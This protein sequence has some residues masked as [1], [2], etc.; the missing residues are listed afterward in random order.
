MANKAFRFRIYPTE[1]QQ[2]FFAKNFGCVRFVYNYWLARR[3]EVYEKEKKTLS[4]EKCCKELTALKK[5]ENFSFLKDA[6]SKSLQVSLNHLDMA[7]KNFFSRPD[8]GYP[9]FKSKRRSKRSYSTLNIGGNIRIE[10]RAIRLPKVGLVRM[11]KHREIPENYVLKSVTV[12]QKPTGAYEV[13]ILF[14]YENQVEEKNPISFLGLDFSMHGLYKDSEGREPAYPRFYR[15]A[16]ARLSRAQRRL[17]KMERGSKNW[18][19]QRLR[20]ARLHEKVANQRRDFL[21]KV[22]KVL[23][24]AY[25]CICVEDLNMKAMSQ[26]LRFGKSV[27][28]NGWGMFLSFLAYKLEDQ[29]K[30]LVKVDR[31]F[32]STQICSVC[33]YKNE[34]TKDLSLRAWDCPECG[35]HHDRDINAAVNIRNE[36]MRLVLA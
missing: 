19:K 18:E 4:Y 6:D 30:Q 29:G 32:P 23:A 26:A 25:D 16:E 10:G 34:K 15:E 1:A 3:I 11:K 7:F 12:S 17:S 33:G 2:A 21:H 13:S 24:D 36:G 27:A 14:F 22:A 9:R 5:E 8:V 28:D 35:T 31:F 20:V